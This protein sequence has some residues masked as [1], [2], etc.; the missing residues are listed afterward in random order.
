VNRNEAFDPIAVLLIDVP[1][2]DD[3]AELSWSDLPGL[4]VHGY[5]R[6]RIYLRHK[7]MPFAKMNVELDEFG[8]PLDPIPP[9][10]PE[11]VHATQPVLPS[12]PPLVS[13]VVA[14]AGL[15]PD[16]L[17]RC[18]QSLTEINYPAF[19][20]VIVDNRA[21]QIVDG[22]E[23]LWDGTG[24]QASPVR[25]VREGRRG[26]SFARN[27]GVLEARGEIVAFTDDD[28]E[29][30]ANWLTGIVEAFSRSEDI[31]CVTGL[32]IPAE[33][34]TEA[35]E[36]CEIFYGGFDRGLVP[37]TWSIRRRRAGDRGSLRRSSFRIS[38][39]GQ[40]D[41]S[42]MKSIYVVAGNCGVGANFA[43]RRDF[44]LTC[45]FDV[46]LGVGSVA[47]SGEDT[48]FYADVLWAGYEVAYVTSSIVRHTHRRGMDELMSQMRGVGVGL[49]AYLA[50]LIFEDSRHLI[51]I[52][53]N[54]APSALFRWV[55][56]AFSG[57]S[58]AAGRDE[59]HAYSPSFRRTE[60]IGMMTGPWLY[61]ASRRHARRVESAD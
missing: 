3:H 51:G 30:D 12:P 59:K 27:T 40:A 44:A 15:R 60:I 2:R 6:A 54:G 13:I 21:Q 53:L 49:T 23:P 29:V 22:D 28:V 19:E 20:I 10:P 55:R 42:N 61:L 57:Q 5:R 38:E 1:E 32:V 41:Q 56:S 34:E 43:A 26:L 48:R 8:I 58:A 35:Q 37:R 18:I 7:G 16:L 9:I 47:R 46:A 25:V 52:M 45:P 11:I 36:L 4:P 24:A 33:L 17:H 50:S 31:K 39:D 14:T